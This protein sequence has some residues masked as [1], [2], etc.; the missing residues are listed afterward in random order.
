MQR[1]G[2]ISPKKTEFDDML[3][4]AVQRVYATYGSDLER[5]SAA[6]Q[7]E[8]K[9]QSREVRQEAAEQDRGKGFRF[10]PPG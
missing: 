2:R 8:L 3:D 4:R 1:Y 5:F 7:K 10:D 6:V 9:R